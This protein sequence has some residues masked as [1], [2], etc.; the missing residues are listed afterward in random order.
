VF[1]YGPERPVVDN[2][3]ITVQAGEHLALVGRTGAGKSSL[4]HLICGLYAPWSGQVLVTGRNPCRLADDERRRVVGVV[5]QMVQ[6]FSGTVWDNLTLGDSAVSDAAVERAARITG[7]DRFVSAL[8]DGYQTVIGGAGRGAGAQFSE[9]Q[10]QLF[11]LARALVWDP[12]A[13]LLDEATASIDHASEVAFRDAL[14]TALQA[15]DDRQRA[16][17]TVAHRLST[18]READRIVLLEDGRIVEHGTPDELLRL[19]GTFA[20]LVELEEAG[21]DWHE[22]VK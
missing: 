7:V 20:A 9:G 16:V 21:W 3:S 6:L 5:P 14:S 8:P 22:N 17:I 19:G 12:V 11:S 4:I 15:D 2:V 10:Q 1:G 13:L 18:A